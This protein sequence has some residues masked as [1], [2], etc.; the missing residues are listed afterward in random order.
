MPQLILFFKYTFAFNDLPLP[1]PYE[2][3]LIHSFYDIVKAYRGPANSLLDIMFEING[4]W[5]H[6]PVIKF[7]IFMAIHLLQFY[8]ILID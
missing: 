3:E 2:N 5:V 8:G 6:F 1:W 7:C 4:A